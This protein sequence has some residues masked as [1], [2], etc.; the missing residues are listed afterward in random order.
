VSPSALAAAAPEADRCIF[1]EEAV[2]RIP[3]PDD[4]DNL[5]NALDHTSSFVVNFEMYLLFPQQPGWILLCLVFR[6][7]SQKQKETP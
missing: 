4:L 3:G 5:E 2:G 6:P 7:N 1:S